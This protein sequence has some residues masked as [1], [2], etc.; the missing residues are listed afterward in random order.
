[1]PKPW[2]WWHRI[3][4]TKPSPLAVF[5]ELDRSFTTRE[6]DALRAVG[7]AVTVLQ[8]VVLQSVGSA[9]GALDLMYTY[10]YS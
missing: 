7:A 10:D 9:I 5:R 4:M 8:S 6:R 1:M 3:R 2:L